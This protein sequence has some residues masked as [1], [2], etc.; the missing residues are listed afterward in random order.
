MSRTRR[1]AFVVSSLVGMPLAR[2]ADI[3]T[4]HHFTADLALEGNRAITAAGFGWTA[5]IVMNAAVVAA[6]AACTVYWWRRPLRL[7]APPGRQTAWR[8]ASF[9]YFGEACSAGR[10]LARSLVGMPRNWLMFAQL[11][12][13]V[14]PVVLIAGSGMAVLSWFAVYAW[15]WSAYRW[16]YRAAFPTF[17]Y[18][19]LLPLGLAAAA[20][21]VESEW[22]RFQVEARGP[23]GRG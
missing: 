13:V 7:A 19:L 5:I 22:R 23:T 16:A 20:A 3:A 2:G 9:N 8:L 11:V 17:P 18:L 15:H 21:F 1:L 14:A 10:L 4:T 12:G 6:V